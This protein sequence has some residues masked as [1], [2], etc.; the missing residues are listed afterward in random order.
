M[1]VPK[2]DKGCCTSPGA[3]ARPEPARLEKSRSVLDCIKICV[4]VIDPAFPMPTD[5]DTRVPPER[6]KPVIENGVKTFSDDQFSP[7]RFD[8]SNPVAL[9]PAPKPMVA[10]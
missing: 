10:K 8:R 1:R 9:P 5:A 4:A 6:C 3:C 2:A 7:E